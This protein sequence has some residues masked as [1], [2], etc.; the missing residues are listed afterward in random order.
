ME[1]AGLTIDERGFLTV[2]SQCKTSV[3]HI[4]AVGDVTGGMMLAHKASAQ[5]KVAAEVIAGLPAVFEPQCIPAVVFS[6][7]EIGTVGLREQEARERFGEILVGKFPFAA[8][9]KAISINETAGFVKIIAK[10]DGTVLGVHAVGPGVTDYI[11]EAGLAIE[12]GASAEDIAL[13]IHPHPTL[14]ESIAEAAEAL[15]GR[16]IHIYQPRKKP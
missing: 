16:S 8:L 10:Q 4:Y 7:P 9:G 15:L 5:G 12:L 14:G 11:A 3:G 6:D 2:D 1:A 13:T